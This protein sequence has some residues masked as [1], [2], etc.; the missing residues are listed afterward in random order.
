MMGM[1]MNVV[2]WLRESGLRVDDLTTAGVERADAVLDVAEGAEGARFVA[3]W[4]SRAPYPHEVERLH[5]A[6]QELAPLGHP[7]LTAPFI[8][9]SVGSTLIDRGW[10]WADDQ[11]NF[12]LRAPG[13]VLRQRRSNLPPA[14][15]RTT[16]PKGSGSLAIIRSLVRSPAGEPVTGVSTLARLSGV[17]QPRASQVLRQLRDLGLAENTAHGRWEPRR[18]ELADRF[19][20]EYPGPGGSES[21]FYSLDPPVETAVRASAAACLD[22]PIVASADVGPDLIAPWRQPSMVILY[23]SR[24]IDPSALGLVSAQGTHDANV[25]VRVPADQSVFPLPPLVAQVKG[26]DVLLADPL[27]QIW[28]L[29]ALGGSDRE[30]A[31]GRLREWLLTHP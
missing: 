16:L 28:D 11:G 1:L 21:Y 18:K 4:R 29:E 17:S 22:Q 6:W 5:G 12:D 3:E 31:A 20:A 10:S 8:S 2:R 27:Q 19:L 26:R 24:I 13:L 30:E 15:R 25:I 9:E 14:V 7:L 23:A